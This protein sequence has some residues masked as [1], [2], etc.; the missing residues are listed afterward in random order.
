MNAIN[1]TNDTT[2]QSSIIGLFQK[3]FSGEEIKGL[4]VGARSSAKLAQVKKVVE[5]IEDLI[6]QGGF[7]DGHNNRPVE[8]H[9]TFVVY[10][11]GNNLHL[12]PAYGVGGFCLN[13]IEKIGT[14][15]KPMLS[16]WSCGGVVYS[17]K[18]TLEGNLRD[19]NNGRENRTDDCVLVVIKKG[20]AGYT[21]KPL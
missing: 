15:F 1:T 2:V 7:I 19:Y 18:D 4:G 21:V 8:D 20:D 11:K 9:P 16:Q 3:A 14:G 10:A 17:T 6:G 12:V 13:P 5:I